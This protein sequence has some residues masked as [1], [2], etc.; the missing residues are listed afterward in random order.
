[1]EISQGAKVIGFIFKTGAGRHRNRLQSGSVDMG[2]ESNRAI[3]EGR[4]DMACH[5]LDRNGL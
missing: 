2:W 3:L 5:P 1:M 4:K